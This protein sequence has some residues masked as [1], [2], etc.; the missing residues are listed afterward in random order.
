[1]QSRERRFQQQIL[2]DLLSIFKDINDNNYKPLERNRIHSK[3][4]EIEPKTV[5]QLGD[6]A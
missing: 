4:V 2:T 5:L 3:M 1:M 6:L